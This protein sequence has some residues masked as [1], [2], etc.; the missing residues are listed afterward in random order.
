MIGTESSYFLFRSTQ[1][2]AHSSAVRVLR[3]L[4]CA[5]SH[6]TFGRKRCP[7]LFISDVQDVLPE[8]PGFW[9]VGGHR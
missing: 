6:G 1:N 9:Q 4:H 7:L 5:C 8:G 2:S 3:R